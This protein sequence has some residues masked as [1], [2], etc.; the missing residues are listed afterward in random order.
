MA[1]MTFEQTKE[2]ID[3]LVARSRKAQ[4]YFEHNYKDQHSIDE[5]ARIAGKSVVDA[6]IKLAQEAV[7][8]TGMGNFEGKM[9]KLNAVALGQ[10][11]NMKGKQSVGAVDVPGEPGVKMMFK[12]LGVIGAAMPSTNPIA[13]VIGNAMMAFKCRNSVLI[14]PHPKSAKSSYDTTELIRAGLKSIGAPEDLIICVEPEKA[15][16]DATN[17]LLRACDVN[18]ATGG[19]GMVKAVYSAGKPAFGVGQGNCQCIIDRELP[20][21]YATVAQAVVAC[22][23]WDNGV[24]CTGEQNAHVPV[25]KLDEFLAAFK[26]CGAYVIDDDETIAKLTELVFPGGGPINRAVVGKY[27]VEVAA[28]IG[29]EIPKETTIL[30]VK[31]QAKGTESPLCKEILFPIVRYRTYETFEEAVDAAVANLEVEGAGHS[32]SIW[33]YNEA[34]IAY[35]ADLIPVG[36]FHVCQPTT[37]A[38]NGIPPTITLGCGSWGNNSI[39]ENLQW[40]HLYNKTRISTFLP[41]ARQMN[42]ETDWDDW[43]PFNP[44]MD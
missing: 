2:Y 16:I 20:V 17:L 44:V 14:A 6:G 29:L 43:E 3:S 8:E 35:A 38:N 33:T 22:R 25:E 23:A 13:T 30:L 41:N 10:W 31:N 7:G 39:S 36:R 9:I 21:D 5:V 40:Y 19:A 11:N 27:P 24:P 15:S 32:S 42:P 34:H 12:P 1:E 26:A 37:G 4:K 18:I 28:M